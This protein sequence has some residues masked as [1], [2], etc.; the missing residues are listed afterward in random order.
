[1]VASHLRNT[2]SFLLM[3]QDVRG[4][5]G[6]GCI[7]KKWGGTRE[8]RTAL[9]HD[10]MRWSPWIP[11]WNW[12]RVGGVGE[13]RGAAEWYAVLEDWAAIVWKHGRNS[14]CLLLG[15]SASGMG[16]EEI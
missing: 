12:S 4:K 1:M 2:P 16:E 15:T 6:H 9:A 11:S 8:K 7:P 3:V 14:R 10:C 5:Y 13:Q